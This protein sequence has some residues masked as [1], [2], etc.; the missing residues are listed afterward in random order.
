MFSKEQ[1]N[2]RLTDYVGGSLMLKYNK[3]TIGS[4]G[5]SAQVAVHQQYGSCQLQ[6]FMGMHIN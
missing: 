4:C 3:R 6:Y 2:A 1:L 5:V